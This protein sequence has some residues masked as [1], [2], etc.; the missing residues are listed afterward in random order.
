MVF[1]GKV[2]FGGAAVDPPRESTHMRSA[3]ARTIRY[4]TDSSR[5]FQ[6]NATEGCPRS[7]AT[8]LMRAVVAASIAFAEKIIGNALAALMIPAALPDEVFTFPAIGPPYQP[9][10]SPLLAP[11]L[12]SWPSMASRSWATIGD[13]RST[14]AN[15]NTPTR[16][17]Y[18]SITCRLTKC[19]WPQAAARHLGLRRHR[20]SR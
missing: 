3:L 15:H 8:K 6:P 9:A 2:P 18:R 11:S 7:P 19:W 20:S 13:F 12:L 10:E 1:A 5:A 4:S 14:P 17:G 16:L